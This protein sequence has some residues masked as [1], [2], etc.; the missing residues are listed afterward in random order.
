[1]AGLS[2]AR[3]V[4]SFSFNCTDVNPSLSFGLFA[5]MKFPEVPAVW[6]T[7]PIVGGMAVQPTML[8][9]ARAGL[10]VPRMSM[11][12]GGPLVPVNKPPTL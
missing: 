9:L 3:K 8:L 2:G 10:D 4:R 7:V 12:S 5:P 11:V 6:N 1:M